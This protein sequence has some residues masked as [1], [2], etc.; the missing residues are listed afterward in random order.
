[1]R[2]LYFERKQEDEERNR[3]F[4]S[5]LK[6]PIKSFN[7]QFQAYQTQIHLNELPPFYPIN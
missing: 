6:P 7:Q 1:M 4:K 5:R 2:P 3:N